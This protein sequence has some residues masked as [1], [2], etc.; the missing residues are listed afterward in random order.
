M[1]KY[2]YTGDHPRVLL[3][4]SQGGN[5]QHFPASGDPSELVE[6]QTVVIEPGDSVQTEEPYAHPELE[7]EKPARTR[8]EPAPTDSEGASK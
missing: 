2:L 7:E 3:G 8:R 4:L 5:A 6:G 1:P